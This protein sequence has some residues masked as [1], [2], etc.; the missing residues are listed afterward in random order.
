[1]RPRGLVT[2]TS[3]KPMK[4]FYEGTTAEAHG[5]SWRVLLDGKPI[6]T[7][8]GTHLELPSK[9]LAQAVAQEWASQGEQI[10]PKE[11][12]LTTVGCTAVDLVR[13]EI[14]ECVG[15]LLPYL[16]MDTLCFEDDN[17]ILAEMQAKEWQPMREWFQAHFGVQLAVA[18]G[19]NAPAHPQPTLPT[20]EKALF[21]YD[22][23]ELSALEIATSTAKSLIVATS[24]VDR[25]DFVA[26][27]AFRLALLEEHFQ[28]EKWGLVEG[29][30]DV[31]HE[32]TM[33]WLETCR[34][35]GRHG[36]MLPVE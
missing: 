6:K 14:G 33:M 10:K 18:R 4:R 23:W 2:A 21:G 28:I 20:V 3:P 16:A 7:P 9:P 8:K 22:E 34:R 17:E 26:K 13:P 19:I 31:S 36:R 24:L 27:D 35:F 32:E 12:P 5:A 1:V 29:E 15:R 30:H 25:E 11:M